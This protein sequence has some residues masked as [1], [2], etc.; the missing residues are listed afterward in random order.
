MMLRLLCIG[1]LL[2]SAGAFGCGG[3]TEV[4]G[5][6]GTVFIEPGP[7]CTAFCALAVGDCEV[8]ELGDDAACEQDCEQQRALAD[9]TSEACL[10]AFEAAIDCSAELDCQ[11]IYDQINRVNL[12]SY[13]CLPEIENS[14]LT[15][16]QG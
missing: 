8:T 11:H 14:D 4:D 13:P 10:E 7:T 1:S 9:Q 3:G 5:G 2:L 12:E 15:C 6:G 16:T